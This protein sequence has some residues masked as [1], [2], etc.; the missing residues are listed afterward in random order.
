M[1]VSND[2]VVCMSVIHQVPATTIAWRSQLPS[3]VSLRRQGFGRPDLNHSFHV[4]PGL[5]TCIFHV[6][7]LAY[8]NVTE[9]IPALSYA[10]TLFLHLASAMVHCC[11]YDFRWLRDYD[12]FWAS[13]QSIPPVKQAAMMACLLYYDL[14]TSLLMRYLGNNYTGAYRL[15]SDVASVLR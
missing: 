11:F 9:I 2:A 1:L 13:Q 14:D 3:R 4:K 6:L 7:R 5:E 12:T 15:V 8:L 10:H